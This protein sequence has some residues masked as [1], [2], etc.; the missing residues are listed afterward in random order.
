QT[1]E[2]AAQFGISVCTAEKDLPNDFDTSHAILVTSVH[3]LFNGLTKFRL[4]A[5]SIPVGALVMDDAH[6]C[7]DSIREQ[8]SITLS[9][10]DAAYSEIASLFESALKD[11][12]A[13]T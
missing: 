4:G 1:C 5:R 6:A 8:V 7:I 12:G 3:K 13:G 2:Q 10:K 11:Q 9:Y